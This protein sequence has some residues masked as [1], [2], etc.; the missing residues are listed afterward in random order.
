MKLKKIYIR[1]RRDIRYTR[2]APERV[3]PVLTPVGYPI[4]PAY[5]ADGVIRLSALGAVQTRE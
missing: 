5:G 1:S 2:K 3:L 4:D